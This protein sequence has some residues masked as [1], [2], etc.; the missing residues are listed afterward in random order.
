MS[1]ILDVEKEILRDQLKDLMEENEQ[2]KEKNREL[3]ERINELEFNSFQDL[4]R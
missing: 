4:G 1:G 3:Q 2:L